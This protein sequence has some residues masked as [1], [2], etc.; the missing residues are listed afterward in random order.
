MRVWNKL[1]LSAL[2]VVTCSSA[3]NTLL[4]QQPAAAPAASAASPIK[5]AVI[6]VG[7]IV[8]N[9]PS[10]KQQQTAMRNQVKATQEELIKRRDVLVKDAEKLKDL[11]EGSPEF[12]SL[13]E[14]LAREEA[15][16]KLDSVRKE[17]EID[18]VGAKM[19]IEFY[20]QMQ[21]II[22]RFAE[23]NNIE[24]VLQCSREQPDSKQPATIQ[25]ALEKSVVY[26]KKTVDLTDAVLQQIIAETPAG[27]TTAPAGVPQTAT[28]PG[29]TPG[30]L[31]R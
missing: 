25:M 4:A 28:P 6:D 24:I 23:Y 16:L 30:N 3:A 9:H 10:I 8:K 20:Q 14:R 12:N 29:A 26:Y 21:G 11:R 1:A 15:Q 27:A 22:T 2:T 5:V 13:Q 31:R 7:Y 19:A 17:K 18:E